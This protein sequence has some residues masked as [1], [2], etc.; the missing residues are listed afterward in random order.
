MLPPGAVH[1]RFGLRKLAVDQP[2]LLL[3]PVA[4]RAEFVPAL[5]VHFAVAGDI[6]GRRLEREVRHRKRQEREERLVGMTG[7]VLLQVPDRVVGHGRGG[8]VAAVGLDRR[9]RLVVFGVLLGGEVAVVVVELVG[10][11]EA[12]VGHDLGAPGTCHLPE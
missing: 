7:G 8:V 2:H 5:P 6:L 4:L 11:V 10:A 9:Q 1:L 3:P 12:A